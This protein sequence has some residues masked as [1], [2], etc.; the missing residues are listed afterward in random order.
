MAAWT[1]V[2][3]VTSAEAQTVVVQMT[4]YLPT[5]IRAAGPEFLG[6]WYDKNPN[7][8]TPILQVER[9]GPW[10]AY[11]GGNAVRIWRT[12]RDLIAQVMRGEKSPETG[13]AEIVKTTR[14]LIKPQ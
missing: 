10:G 14:D 9:A 8:R 7:A 11:P 12:Q 2:K 1:F 3:Y 6:P 5:N 13:F 4:G